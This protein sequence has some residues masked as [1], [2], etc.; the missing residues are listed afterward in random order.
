MDNGEKTDVAGEIRGGFFQS[1]VRTTRAEM[2]REREEGVN[3]VEQL[4]IQR[5]LNGEHEGAGAKSQ[6]SCERNN[7][8]NTRRPQLGRSF[9]WPSLLLL[10]TSS[11]GVHRTSFL[12]LTR[13]TTPDVYVEQH[14]HGPRR[15]PRRPHREQR[16]HPSARCPHHGTCMS[17][18]PL[19]AS[20]P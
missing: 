3:K 5:N 17:A 9:K 15:L 6:P 16:H 18:P 13:P 1:S 12:P 20:R 2:R 4:E 11:T 8:P 19:P 14:R 10:H 7:R